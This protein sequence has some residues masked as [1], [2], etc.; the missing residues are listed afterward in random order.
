[1]KRQITLFSVLVVSV[2]LLAG[3][4]TAVLYWH[5]P[6]YFWLPVALLLLIIACCIWLIMFSRRVY[7]EWMRRFV[8]ALDAEQQTALQRFPLPA[9]LLDADGA[10]LYAND[11]FSRQ[12]TDGIR[13]IYGTVAQHLFEELTDK[14]LSEKATVEIEYDTHKYT[15]YISI[16]SR[17]EN[18]RYAVYF[19]DNTELKDI[20]EEYEATRPVVL[21]I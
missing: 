14:A 9:I 1:M 12:V 6:S 19:V 21:Q 11:L 15:A 16:I 5:F 10:L 17:D 3:G 20:A 2:A 18:C 4:C 7:T 8:G 13:P